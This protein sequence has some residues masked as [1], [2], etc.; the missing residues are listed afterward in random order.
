MNKKYYI[1]ATLLILVALLLASC[2]G[3]NVNTRALRFYRM[4]AGQNPKDSMVNYLSPAFRDELEKQG[5]LKVFANLSQALHITSAKTKELK[6]QNIHS[7]RLGEFALTWVV[8]LPDEPLVGSTPMK[9]VR[10]RGKWYLYMG[11]DAELKAYKEFPSG[12]RAPKIVPPKA[13]ETSEKPKAGAEAVPPVKPP[14]GQQPPAKQETGK[15]QAKPKGG[16]KPK[17][18]GGAAKPPGK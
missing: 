13:S 1:A 18:G 10:V 6:A 2:A 7:D 14:A 8:G 9:W 17:A 4:L 3:Q 11:S 15:G 16:E 5:K 12:L